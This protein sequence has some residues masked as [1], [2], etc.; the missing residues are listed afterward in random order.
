MGQDDGSDNRRVPQDIPTNWASPWDY[1]VTVSNELAISIASHIARGASL[2]SAAMAEM[3]SPNRLR[4]WLRK[5]DEAYQM[6]VGPDH[7]LAQYLNLFLKVM[8]AIGFASVRLQAQ[9]R[10]EAPGWWLTH[11]PQQKGDW[12]VVVNNRNVT[13]VLESDATVESQ[14]TAEPETPQLPKPNPEQ[15]KSILRTLIEGGAAIG[16]EDLAPKPNQ[17]SNGNAGDDNRK[18]G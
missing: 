9:V 16:S 11:N 6:E 10:L 7:P 2:N 17:S 13:D 18:I 12:S 15:V 8:Q 1:P 5:G 4:T 3:V 14:V